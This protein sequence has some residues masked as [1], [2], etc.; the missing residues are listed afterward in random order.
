M[1]ETTTAK[2]DSKGALTV[3]ALGIIVLL[4]LAL[5]L[6]RIEEESVCLEEYVCVAH[7]D[8]PDLVTFIRQVRS[9]DPPMAPLSFALAYVWS[10]LAGDSIVTV[11]LLFVIIGA[12][13]IPLA[14]SFA[15]EFY[16]GNV[17]GRRAGL[18][19][20]LC[21]AMSPVHIF[22]AQE[23][24]FYALLTLLA[25][26][27]AYSLMKALRGEGVR[28]WILNVLA[29][30][31]IP[32]THLL[33]AFVLFTEGLFL[34]V[35]HFRK[36]RTIAAWSLAHLILL[37]PWA[38]WLK[39]MR[40]EPDV[41]SAVF[42][43]PRPVALFYDL[44]ADDVA[45]LSSAGPR[46]AGYTWGFIPPALS[47][48]IVAIH[49]W[50]DGM[51]I[52]GFCIAALWLAWRTAQAIRS[53]HGRGDGR[54]SRPGSGECAFLLMWLV[55]PILTMVALG[56]LWRPCYSSRYSIYSS[57]ALYLAAGGAIASIPR[58]GLRTG[59]VGAL[60]VLY[61]YQAS[62]ALPGPAR[63]DWKSAA[64][65]IRSTGT[66]NDL[67]LVEDP[68]WKPIFLFNTGDTP[69]PVSAAFTSE[70]LCD[71]AAFFLEECA[72]A[73][74]DKAEPPTAWVLLVH[75]HSPLP[76]EELEECIETRGLTFALKEFPGER[77]L[78][79]YHVKRD[80]HAAPSEYGPRM[81]ALAR[82]IAEHPNRTAL[83]E[84]R[85]RIEHAP[86][87]STAY[88]RMAM[89]LAE[90]GHVGPA[91]AALAKASRLDFRYAMELA[92]LHVAFV[93]DNAYER[94]VDTVFEDLR[95]LSQGTQAVAAF[96]QL[97][98]E[99][100]RFDALLAVARKAVELDPAFAKAYSSLGHALGQRGD[101]DGAIRAF[102]KAIELDPDQDASV[103]IGLGARL[104]TVGENDA[105]REVFRHGIE[106]HPEAPW[107][108][109][110]LA[111]NLM[112]TG[113][114]DSAI[115]VLRKAVELDPT[116]QNI[117]KLLEKALANR[118]P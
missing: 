66:P 42:G 35:F 34:I 14:Y 65:F 4:G 16:G 91:S 77:R 54:P 87:A 47:Q 102:R 96:L 81:E 100:G 13:I 89:A 90:K 9:S 63:T 86:G 68:F 75:G 82:T 5:R 8:A 27:S 24:R 37:I 55:V 70:S 17:F 115:A 52:A 39:T 110:H 53:E 109:A 108:H 97:L 95:G 23:V 105:A 11:R 29:N 32:W 21:V 74:A 101:D 57:L 85:K 2:S 111:T 92:Y 18:V 61:A 99:R 116:E 104:Q 48:G 1:T 73:E 38:F 88:V 72:R 106:R 6:Y 113:D 107:L 49:P 93:E 114:Y 67:I 31:L 10:R 41:A 33:G 118:S 50:L 43:L 44:F 79:L 20:A 3:V 28:W 78:L 12:F 83:A 58:R 30:I 45:Y 112:A 56:Y 22:H 51:M 64:A 26:V 80:P 36:W 117:R 25:V 94:V 40:P 71:S 60:A 103:Y 19:A 84:F 46:P 69:H 7:L 98:E 62:L 15:R 76:P 59:A